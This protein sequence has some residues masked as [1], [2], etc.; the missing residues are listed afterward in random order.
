MTSSKIFSKVSFFTII[1]KDSYL[2]FKLGIIKMNLSK[3]IFNFD[4][5][6][7]FLIAISL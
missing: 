4:A 2:L 1:L 5:W 3:I 7:Y 6:D